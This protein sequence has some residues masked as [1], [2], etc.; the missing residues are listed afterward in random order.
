MGFFIFKNLLEKCLVL[1]SKSKSMIKN[2]IKVAVTGNIGSG[3]SLFCNF[4]T[5]MGFRVIKADDVSKKILSEDKEVREKVVKEF[6]EESFIKNEINKKFLAEKI[7]SD[8]SKVIKI[9]SILHPE[10]KKKILSLNSGY[11]KKNDLVFTEAAL[12]YEADME[13]MFDYV[14]LISADYETRKK[15]AMN[16][17]NISESDFQKRN[18]NQIRNE[19]KK[20]R[21]DF[22]FDNNG[23][24]EGLKQKADLLITILT[25]LVK[26]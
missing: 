1:N 23:N 17:D 25:G 10:V 18:E 7:F 8:P 22:V 12:I 13:S 24:A 2:K 20:K 26:K 11:F 3:K 6:G 5:E 9:N 4:L 15:R 19:E 16:N 14:V 21:A